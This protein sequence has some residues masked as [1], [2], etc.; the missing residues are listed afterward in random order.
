M[1]PMIHTLHTC[2]LKGCTDDAAG[3]G[4]RRA[5]RWVRRMRHDIPLRPG[6]LGQAGGDGWPGGT[7]PTRLP[8]V[9]L[10]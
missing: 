2:V 9:R 6:C 5:V 8:G 3:C 1:I 10:Q 7:S 4:P